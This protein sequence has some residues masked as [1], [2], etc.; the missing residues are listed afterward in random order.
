MAWLGSSKLTIAPSYCYNYSWMVELECLS[1]HAL[2]KPVPFL[3]RRGP[4]LKLSIMFF[5]CCDLISPGKRARL[6][7]LLASL[8]DASMPD[9]AC[10]F[11]ESMDGFSDY[12]RVLKNRLF[13]F[14]YPLNT[15]LPRS[16]TAYKSYGTPSIVCTLWKLPKGTALLTSSS[17]TVNAPRDVSLVIYPAILECFGNGANRSI[18]IISPGCLAFWYFVPKGTAGPLFYLTLEWALYWVLARI[19]RLS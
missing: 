18:T 13:G 14:S 5:I 3:I 9:W 15:K 16:V 10:R 1:M 17:G 8:L 19:H 2:L 12:L 7:G 4:L 11:V 6:C